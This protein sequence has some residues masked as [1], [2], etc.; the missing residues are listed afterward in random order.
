MNLAKTKDKTSFG[1]VLDL[2]GQ[3]LQQ[4]SLPPN[5]YIQA[6]S[7]FLKFANDAVNKSIQVDNP[8]QIAHI[9]LQFKEGKEDDLAKCESAGNE[10]TGAVAVLR[11]V[12]AQGVPLI[13][14]TNTQQQYCFRY[15]SGSTYEL[16][17][18]KRNDDGSCPAANKYEGV[19]NDYVMLLV[20]AQPVSRPGKAVPPATVNAYKQE[21]SLRCRNLKLP[22]SACGAAR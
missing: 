20:S 22:L 8:E 5:P 6:G 17:A 2:A 16:L 1:A 11:S 4:V 10:R 15:S 19:M 13:P 14:V 18:A 9:G 3:A 21:S 7:K 12:G